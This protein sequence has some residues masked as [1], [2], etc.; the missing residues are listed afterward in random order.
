MAST[1]A[2]D[3]Y[4]E[5]FRDKSK[6]S[7]HPS[8]SPHDNSDAASFLHDDSDDERTTAQSVNTVTNNARARYTVPTQRHQANTGVKGVITD[9]QAYRAAARNHRDGSASR[10]SM[11]RERESQIANVQP[12]VS[13]GLGF[14][15]G[16]PPGSDE[17]ELDDDQDDQFM[18]QWRQNRLRE[19]QGGQRIGNSSREK[20][21]RRARFG[22]MVP[23]DG[24]GF[25]EAV[26]GSG[27]VTVVVVFI[28]DDRSEVSQLFEDCLHTMARKY[29]NTR[30]VKLH[31]Q[32]AEMEPA[33]VPAVLAYRGGDKFAGLVPMLDEIPDD[34][35]VNPQTL[36]VLFQRHQI[37]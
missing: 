9:A 37:L 16:K 23:V 32:D 7:H 30:F 36:E 24:S 35:D 10:A 34:M 6:R 33:G 4:N 2:Q 21:A 25:L 19:L 8:D 17:D 20:D 12:Y 11:Q 15:D 31:Y 3:E 26:D 14:D 18:D 27:S 1:A 28:Y 13:S 5:L 29:I 22:G